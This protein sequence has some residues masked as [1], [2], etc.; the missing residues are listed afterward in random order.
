MLAYLLTNK[1]SRGIEA[2]VSFGDDYLYFMKYILP[3]LCEVQLAKAKLLCSLY[4]R[5]YILLN[6]TS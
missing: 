6:L 5:K 4:F 2:L 1:L 3:L